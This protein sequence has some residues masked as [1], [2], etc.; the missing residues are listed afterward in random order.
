[1]LR[2]D[3]PRLDLH[4][5]AVR[6]GI[7]LLGLILPVALYAYGQ[8]G[9]GRMQPSISE[10]YYTAMGDVFVG[11]LTAIGVFLLSYRG[12]RARP[13]IFPL[14]DRATS[15]IAGLAALGVAFLPAG[16][17]PAHARCLAGGTPGACAGALPDPTLLTGLHFLTGPLHFACAAVFFLA[18]AW[19]CLVLFPMGGRRRPDGGPALSLEH[20]TYYI[21]GGILI[22]AILAALA[23]LALPFKDQM[24]AVNYIFWVETAGVLAFAVAWLVKGHA[25]TRPLGFRI[26]GSAE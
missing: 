2:D 26:A 19:F 20:L 6:Q 9:A 5:L 3:D 24:R 13:A 15:I 7:G 16:A 10:F 11:C 12:Y 4:F 22:A 25:L 1:M 14:G 17:D 21:C 18:L 8:S 23:Y